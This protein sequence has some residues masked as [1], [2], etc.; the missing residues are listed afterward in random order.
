MV[1]LIYVQP[2]LSP[3]KK[4]VK[5][6]VLL[7]RDI[8]GSGL[9]ATQLLSFVESYMKY[10]MS[11]DAPYEK[12]EY[13]VVKGQTNHRKLIPIMAVDE[14]IKTGFTV[15]SNPVLDYIITFPLFPINDL[16]GRVEELT[17]EKA[18]EIANIILVLPTF[19]WVIMD[20]G[21]DCRI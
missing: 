17:L 7:Y 15:F 3:G 18:T 12:W 9:E 4:P 2:S 11:I 5:D 20:R 6:L 14:F 19:V 13:Q 8:A 10:A 1:E 16:I 21:P